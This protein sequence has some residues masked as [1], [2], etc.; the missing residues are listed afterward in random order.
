MDD[1]QELLEVFDR[2]N[3]LIG[4]ASRGMIHRLGLRHRAVHIFIFDQAGRLYL[5]LR[6]WD[7]DQ[8]PGHWDSSAAGH[9]SP[10]E[11][12]DAAAARELAEELGIRE[13][14]SRLAEVR[15]CPETG[16]EQVMLFHGRTALQPVTNPEEIETGGF[17]SLEE[18]DR[19][20]VDANMPVTSAFRLLYGLWKDLVGR[21]GAFIPPCQEVK[22]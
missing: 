14:L 1:Q 22:P 6:R 7:K 16:W 12:Y 4:Q 21:K 17:F 19:M 9:V 3:R 13:E 18:I 11:S 2:W 15:A 10:G 5:Q 8:Y 20:V